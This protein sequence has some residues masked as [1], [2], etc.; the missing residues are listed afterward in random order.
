MAGSSTAAAVLALL[1]GASGFAGICLTA[2]AGYPPNSIT[3]K[4]LV[5]EIIFEG[6]S[7]VAL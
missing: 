3:E 4:G 2:P 7:F 5:R 1:I 6:N